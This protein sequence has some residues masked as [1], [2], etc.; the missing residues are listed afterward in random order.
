[1]QELFLRKLYS[2]ENQYICF[3]LRK[4]FATINS[5]VVCLPPMTLTDIKRERRQLA[6]KLYLEHSSNPY[7]D[8]TKLIVIKYGTDWK[9]KYTKKDTHGL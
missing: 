9:T 1:M 2:A 3:F 4:L 8:A 5:N 6:K 7:M